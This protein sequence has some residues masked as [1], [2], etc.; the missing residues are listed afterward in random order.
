MHD[1]FSSKKQ[2]ASLSPY[3][4]SMSSLSFCVD[5]HGVIVE[6]TDALSEFIELH[7]SNW[8][9]LFIDKPSLEDVRNLKGKDVSL[10]LDV[11]SYNKPSILDCDDVENVDLRL[12]DVTLELSIRAVKDSAGKTYGATVELVNPRSAANKKLIEALNRSQ[13]VIEFD[14]DGKI[15]EANDNFLT[16]MG[17]TLDEVKGKHHSLFATEEYK[18]SADYTQFWHDLRAGKFFVDEFKRI[19]KGGREVWLQASYNPIMDV[20]GNPYK[21]VKFASDITEQQIAKAYNLGIVQAISRAQAVI[22]FDLNGTILEANEH[23]LSTMG[24]TLDE[25]KGKHHSLFATEE[26]KNSAD[27]TQFWHDLRAGKFFVDEFK[28]IGKGGREVWLQASYN[29]IMDASGRPYRVVKL[30]TDITNVVNVR[31]EATTQSGEVSANIQTVAGAT[32]ELLASVQEISRS[33]AQSQASINEII[34]SNHTAKTAID[35]LRANAAAM[36]DIVTL[37]RDISEQVNLLALNATIEAARAGEAGKG[38][39]VVANEVKNLANQTANAT[40]QISAEISAMQGLA[41]SVE[42][43]A[44]RI[45]KST[46][47]AGESV[48]TIVSAL[49]EQSAV[50]SEVSDNMQQISAGVDALDKCIDRLAK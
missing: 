15:I 45:E 17:Y 4:T 35:D 38:F 33:M 44:T 12:E 27:Y 13:A 42:D 21:V 43:N 46:L 20:S 37:I 2:T 14:L 24:Y 40:E 36:G 16:T 48:D 50:T 39:A 1:F 26:Y 49:E 28:R 9:K 34:D 7:G 41:K 47:N 25:V 3:I 32:E 10:I 29:P 6:V 19:G 18:N 8:D 31:N 22:E 30:A 11:T 5:T 23:F